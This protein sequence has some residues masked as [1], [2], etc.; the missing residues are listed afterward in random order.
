MRF[1]LSLVLGASCAFVLAVVA[2][3]GTGNSGFN[4]GGDSG[5]G[6]DGGTDGGG[7]DDVTFVPPTDAPPPPPPDTGPPPEVAVRLRAQPVGALQARP[8]TKTVTTVGPFSGGCSSSV[9]DLADRR[10]LER[11]RD[12]VRR[13]LQ[14][15]P[16][17]REVHADRHGQ[18]PE[19]ALLRAQGH[20]RS[21]R[22][23]ARRLRG[24][25]LRPHRHH[26]GRRHE[27]RRPDRRLLVER[28]HRLG[29]ERRHLPHGDRAQLRRL[30][31]AGR[32]GDGQ[33]REE[34]RHAS[35]TR[36]STASPSGP[37]RSYGFDNAGE[38]FE[39]TANGNGIKTT[40]IPV[41]GGLQFWGAGSTTSAPVT[42]KDGGGIIIN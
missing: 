33:P 21:E 28:R 12:D 39:I 36:P 26:H 14:A 23:G 37:A 13:R 2:C 7:L 35:T 25:D 11:L 20:A 5:T 10:E 27:R 16:D 9:I 42:D 22:G 30:P 32:P 31:P 24:L 6:N 34:L 8:L 3:G 15:R 40:A 41:V 38:L 1:R 29:E 19:L 17:D 18:L 4:N